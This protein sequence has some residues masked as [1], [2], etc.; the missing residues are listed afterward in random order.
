M[1]PGGSLQRRL[2]FGIATLLL[3]TLAAFSL[4]AY[5][6]VRQSLTQ[7]A[8][9]RLGVAA[10]QLAAVLSQIVR[11]ETAALEELRSR[12]EVSAFLTN[13]TSENEAAAA[14]V[15]DSLMSANPVRTGVVIR[16]AD[17]APLLLGDAEPADADNMRSGVSRLISEEGRI[18]YYVASVVDRPEGME[19]ISERLQLG[20]GAGGRFIR[21]LIGQGASFQIGNATWDVWTGLGGQ[22]D[23]STPPQEGTGLSSHIEDGT[24]V[25]GLWRPVP[26]TP[27]VVWVDLPA[28]VVFAPLNSFVGRVAAVVIVL[29]LLGGG[30]AWLLGRHVTRPLEEL[31]T[32]AQAI[33]NGDFSNA[34]ATDRSDEIGTLATAF[35]AMGRTLRERQ[36]RFRQVTE[37]I[38]EVFFLLGADFDQMLYVSP[39]YKDIWGEPW[40]ALFRSPKA[41]LEAAL[42]ED[43]AALL[44]AF[45]RVRERETEER[46]EFRIRRP[47]GA[48]RWMVMHA[49]GIR[50][51]SGSTYRIAGVLRDVT[52]RKDVEK[53]LEVSEQRLRTLLESVNLIVLVLA[54]DGSIEYA[55]PFLLEVAGYAH[56]ELI[57][58]NWFHD[59]VRA[60]DTDSVVERFHEMTDRER[61]EK[62]QYVI[63]T[64]DGGEKLISW[65]ET[66]L[67]DGQGRATGTLCVGEDVTERAGLEEQL[68]RAQ[69]MEAVGRLAGGIAHDFNNLLTAILGPAEMLLMEMDAADPARQDLEEIKAAGERAATLTRQLLAFSRQQVLEPKNLDLNTLVGDLDRMLQRIVGEDIEFRVLLANDLGTVRADPGQIEQVIMNLVINSRDAMPSGGTLTFETAN[70]ELDAEYADQHFPV[71]AGQYVMLAVSDTGVG[72]DAAT[73]AKIFEPFFTTKPKGK[74]TGLGLATAY[75]IVKQSGGYIWAYSEVGQGTTFKVYLPRVDEVPAVAVSVAGE[76]G[77]LSG[78]ET[79]LVVEDEKIVQGVTRRILEARG[80]QVLAADGGPQALTIAEEHPGPIPLLI[81]DVVMPEMSGRDLASRLLEIRPATR[82]IYV[83]GYTDDMIVQHGV[84]EPGV[85]FLQKPFTPRALAKKV[86][87]VLDV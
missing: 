14:A 78:T 68:R 54:E 39:G 82:V 6:V 80:Y 51:Q 41:F 76:N 5:R 86:R 40:E 45:G 19:V 64:R 50:D 75:G 53:A 37:A 17:A 22:A 52:N 56:D 66:V 65:H 57:K 18:R 2:S 73:R 72:M 21:D 34:I 79:I 30:A 61:H 38:N 83:S 20:G 60:G 63:L 62:H 11:L 42:P 23:E 55:N 29:L 59:F 28:A 74:G 36:E 81:T 58:K 24:E 26:E 44:Q 13:P 47:D 35:E 9:V 31:T 10:E 32:A 77:T 87:T 4:L 8:E 71:T 1:R 7:V 70:V 84:L 67:R 16:A 15:L 27:W 33:Q 43:R 48:V 85:Q 25:L 69:K 49:R 12:P 3:V 46:H